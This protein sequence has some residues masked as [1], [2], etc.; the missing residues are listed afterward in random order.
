VR[1]P[2]RGLVCLRRLAGS[3]IEAP[4]SATIQLRCPP[5]SSGPAA[6]VACGRPWGRSVS[7]HDR[8]RPDLGGAWP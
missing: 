4:L 8:V 7:R 5:L 3:G 1:P 2:L 6:R